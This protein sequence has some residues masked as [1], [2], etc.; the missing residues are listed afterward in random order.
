[1][2]KV[3]VTGVAG[4][5]GSHIAEHLLRGNN[6]VIGIDDL[7]AGYERNIPEGVIF[8][9]HDIRNIEQISSVFKDV[10]A[11][12]HN[13]ASKKN[14]CLNDPARDMEINGIGTLKLLQ[15]CVNNSVNKFIHAST[16]SVYGE[17]RGVMIESSSKNPRSYYGISKLAAEGYVNYY[18]DKL[19]ITILRY[20]HVYG[21]RQ[22]S[23]PETGGVVAIFTE[24]IK[25]GERITIHGDGLQNRVFTNV[26]DIATANL[27]CWHNDK[28][29]G[30]TY[31]CASSLQMNILELANV[32]MKKYDKRVAIVHDDPSV[33]DIYNF[34]VDNR[35]I[36]E[37]GV[38]FKPITEY[39]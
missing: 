34:D 15:Q 36:R 3:I 11:V 24:K 9:K 16:G 18:R 38:H 27:R 35:K 28:S 32:L 37:I 39:L 1:M 21:D 13:A 14:I 2:A 6:T 17:V 26:S 29:A 23:D 7:S 33:G 30:Q 20:F 10:K 12:F 19:N 25:R 22:E 31:N 5:I 4:F 8:I